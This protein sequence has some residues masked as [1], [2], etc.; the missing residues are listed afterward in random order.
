M[1]PVKRIPK[2][3][4]D[5]VAPTATKPKKKTFTVEDWVTGDGQ[6]IILYADTGM[7][8][9]SLALLAPNPVF[10]GTD[11]GGADFIHPETGVPIKRILPRNLMLGVRQN[12][13]LCSSDSF[14]H[15]A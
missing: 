13:F 6:R 4:P 1:T 9:T 14:I 12:T 5:T 15:C 7:G 2:M 8:K 3:P 10:I 11:E